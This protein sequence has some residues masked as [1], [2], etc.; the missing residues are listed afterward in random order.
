VSSSLSNSSSPPGPLV[1]RRAPRR[2]ESGA[3]LPAKAISHKHKKR[4][5]SRADTASG[6]GSACRCVDGAPQ[7]RVGRTPPARLRENRGAP[8]L[9]PRRPAA[10]TLA[11]CYKILI[12]R[13]P[14]MAEQKPTGQERPVFTDREALLFHSRGRPGKLEII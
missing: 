9:P 12:G 2:P 14:H 4:G 10:Y 8:S 1:D 11:H 13:R 7:R 3:T 6:R 5:L